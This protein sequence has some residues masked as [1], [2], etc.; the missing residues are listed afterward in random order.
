MQNKTYWQRPKIFKTNDA[1]IKCEI[2][3][4]ERFVS[5]LQLTKS[6]VIA[7]EP[8]A[9]SLTTFITNETG[10]D[11]FAQGTGKIYLGSDYAIYGVEIIV[12]VEEDARVRWTAP[13]CIMDIQKLNKKP[14]RIS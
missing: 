13:S 4:D 6:Y 10:K 7:K 8:Q 9:V 2:A 12:T 11:I 14:T 1:L 3:Y 5:L